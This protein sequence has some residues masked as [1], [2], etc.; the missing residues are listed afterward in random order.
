M[1]EMKIILGQLLCSLSFELPPDTTSLSQME[2]R[3]DI[4]NVPTGSCLL[5]VRSRTTPT[6][7]IFLVGPQSTGKTT[8]LNAL[9]AKLPWAVT[10]IKEVARSVMAQHSL[11]RTAFN[12]KDQCGRLQ[13]LIFDEQLLRQQRA[14]GACVSDRGLI[15]PV[16]YAHCYCDESV[17]ADLNLRLKQGF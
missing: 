1:L 3:W 16:A 11:D 17:A 5:R 13:K 4:A 2:T 10:S 15:D 12:D 9:E 14:T 6:K 7:H 8:V